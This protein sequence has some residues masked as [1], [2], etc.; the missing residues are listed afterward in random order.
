[1]IT[2]HLP[3]FLSAIIMSIHEIVQSNK[4]II[5][6][7]KMTERSIR[8]LSNGVE[9][10]GGGGSAV[11]VSG[12]DGLRSMTLW[13]SFVSGNNGELGSGGGGFM[14]G[15]RVSIERLGSAWVRSGDGKGFSLTFFR[16]KFIRGSLITSF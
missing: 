13:R 10:G 6:A 8:G 15:S 1:M 5:Q 9:T 16:N 3:S 14:V 11:S 2:Y 12:G 4:M 7:I